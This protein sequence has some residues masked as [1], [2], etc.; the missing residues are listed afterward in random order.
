MFS[1]GGPAGLD[2]PLVAASS[3]PQEQ[4]GRSRVADIMTRR[5]VTIGPEATVRELA[6]LLFDHG[7]SGVP[8]VDREG[9]LL[10]VASQTDVAAYAARA[11][12]GGSS[13]CLCGAVD[14]DARVADVMSPYTYFALEETG[15]NEL[16][17]MML[18]RHIHRVVV[19]R[20][21]KLVGI[22]SSLD[23]LRALTRT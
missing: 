11:L 12:P 9:N 17:E 20:D 21:R 22:V 5:I 1:P 19:V 7:I 16:A 10:G 15:L 8:V 14:L 4:T 13:S 3:A 23:L 18:Q 2:V 6:Q